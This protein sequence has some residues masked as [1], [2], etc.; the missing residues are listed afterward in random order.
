[1]GALLLQFKAV[2]LMIFILLGHWLSPQLCILWKSCLLMGP[3]MTVW[4]PTC[5][6]FIRRLLP[7]TF[8]NLYGKGR[9]HIF[10]L[11][12]VS[13]EVLFLIERYKKSG[14]QL[15]LKDGRHLFI[16]DLRV[17]FDDIC[18]LVFTLN[19]IRWRIL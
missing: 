3:Y 2:H 6:V 19:D 18:N 16:A 1:M 9:G 8:V 11:W 4:H 5:F 14:I 10:A 7:R 15:F 12:L 17:G 13:V